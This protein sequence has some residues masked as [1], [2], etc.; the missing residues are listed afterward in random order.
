MKY[1]SARQS[2][3]KSIEKSFF[4]KRT[5]SQADRQTAFFGVPPPGNELSRPKEV[6]FAEMIY[7]R[8]QPPLYIHFAL[9]AKGESASA[10]LRTDV[11]QTG[12][13]DRLYL[14][15]DT[16]QQPGIETLAFLKTAKPLFA[17][18]PHDGAAIIFPGGNSSVE[19]VVAA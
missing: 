12:G 7:Y 19:G 14:Q 17:A 3:N 16:P 11:Q 15:L 4:E 9:S 10:F 5:T 2:P 1:S 18:I 8:E 6:E 13:F